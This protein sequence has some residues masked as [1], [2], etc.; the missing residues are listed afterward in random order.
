M[1][2]VY[3]LSV[4]DSRLQQTVDAIDAGPSSR[5]RRRCGN[6]CSTRLFYVPRRRYPEYLEQ[7]LNSRGAEGAAVRLFRE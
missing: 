7:A 6:P 5:F 1:P 4:I 2:D 3:S